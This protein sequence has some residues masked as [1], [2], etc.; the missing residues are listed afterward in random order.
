[1]MVLMMAVITIQKSSIFATC[2]R[3]NR[4][5]KSFRGQML[6]HQLKDDGPIILL[7]TCSQLLASARSLPQKLAL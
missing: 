4:C 6:T 2:S 3:P 7:S 5:K 1:M